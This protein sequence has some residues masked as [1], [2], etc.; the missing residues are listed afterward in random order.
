MH[1]VVGGPFLFGVEAPVRGQQMIQSDCAKLRSETLKKYRLDGFDEGKH[2]PQLGNLLF[3][4]HTAH[5]PMYTGAYY[6]LPVPADGDEA[7]VRENK[8][9]YPP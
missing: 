3:V 9:G 2:P 5:V 1:L 6:P 7:V 4:Q 8:T